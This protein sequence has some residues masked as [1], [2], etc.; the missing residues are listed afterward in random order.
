MEYL[1]DIMKY[2]LDTYKAEITACGYLNNL[3]ET[4]FKQA[5]RN[6]EQFVREMKEIMGE[7]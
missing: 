6:A 3:K 7:E 1:I 4:D 2:D 5:L